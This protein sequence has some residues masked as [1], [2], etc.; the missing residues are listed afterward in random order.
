MRLVECRSPNFDARPDG[1]P[2][3][4]LILHYT[5]MRTAEEA[6]ARLCD[7][8]ARVSAHY[9]IDRDGRVYRH[10]DEEMRAW[11]A[12]VSFW[13][14][15]RN[16]NGRSVGVELVNPGHEFGYVPFEKAQVGALIDLASEILERHPI[17]P[18]RVLGHSDVAPARKSDPGE[19]FPWM[20][21]AEFGIGFFPPVDRRAPARE[22]TLLGSHVA[23]LL[24]EFGYGL[25]P[26]VDVPLETVV[27]AFQRHFQPTKVDGM[28]D[29][30]TVAL[31][32]ALLPQ[33]A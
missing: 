4:M 11:H 3:D 24:A 6:L 20:H 29:A 33:T 26:H 18:H 15:E 21:L 17:P 25:P 9:T 5:G 2:V 27:V 30:E 16:I 23:T 7:P 1:A 14:G 19:L 10:V 22:G 8:D 12:G 32:S 28:A 31:L 13:A